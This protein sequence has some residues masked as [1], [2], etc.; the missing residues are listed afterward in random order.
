VRFSGDDKSLAILINDTND[1]A[2]PAIGRLR[3]FVRISPVFRAGETTLCRTDKSQMLAR[4]RFFDDFDLA[5]ANE[6]MTTAAK[7]LIIK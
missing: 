4:R 2:A 1:P 7:P 5:T 6:F 3:D